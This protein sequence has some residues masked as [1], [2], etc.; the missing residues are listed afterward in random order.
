MTLKTSQKSQSGNT[1]ANFERDSSMKRLFYFGIAIGL[2]MATCATVQAQSCY[3]GAYQPQSA[4][5][6]ALAAGS[7]QTVDI[8]LRVTVTVGSGVSAPAPVAAP[9]QCPDAVGYSQPVALPLMRVYSYAATQCAP[10]GF[11]GSFGFVN[12]GH[13]GGHFNQPLSGNFRGVSGGSNL[14]TRDKR[15]T[16]VNANFNNSVK[17][18]RGIGGNIR[19]VITDANR[20]PLGRISPFN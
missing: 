15:G 17:I 8:P 16:V 4:E 19:E 13:F 14:Q 6:F 2:L 11:T 5:P 12:Q 9:Q 10:T 18:K 7:T 20:G 3:S 1:V